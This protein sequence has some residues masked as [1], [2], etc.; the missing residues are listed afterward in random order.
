M[1]PLSTIGETGMRGLEPIDAIVIERRD[2]AVLAR[3]EP[4]EPGLARVHDERVDAGRSTAR[5]IASSA[6]SGSWS[7]MPMRHLTVTGIRDRGLHGGDA[8]ADQRRLRHQAGAEA[9]LLHAV[10]R[11][12]D[13]EVDLVVAEIR[14]DARALGE[15]ARIAAAELQR[16]R[17]LGRVEGQEPRAVAVQHRAG[18][19]HLGIDQ[20]PARQQ[21]ME[22]PAVPVGPFHHRRDGKLSR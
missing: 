2:V 19:D 22:E 11:T 17:M 7:S 18:G 16:H 3:R 1:P 12:A 6:S 8:V 9:T 13:I 4:F 14:R 10:G 15:L 5:A 20:R 21:A